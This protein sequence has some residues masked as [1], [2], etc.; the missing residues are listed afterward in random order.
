MSN[1]KITIEVDGEQLNA[2]PGQM[3]IEVT[4]AA[5]I[6][7]PR[8]CYHK[9]LSVAANCRMCLVEVEKAPKPLPACATPCMDGMK[10]Y[11]KSPTARAAQK[12]TMEFLLINHP[13]DCPIC[14]QGGECEL[15]DVAM[16][17]GGDVSRYS[18]RKRVVRDENLGPLIATDMTR[19]IHCT[20]CV[21]FGGEVAGLR[22]MGATGRGEH[23][24]IGVFIEQS[25]ASE[26]SG[27][28][29]DLCPVGALTSKPFRYHAR[30]WELTQRDSIAPHDGVGSNLHLHIR[31]DEV[32][33]AVPKENDDCNQTWI[34]DRDRFS[35]S[36]IGSED[37]IKRPMV[38]ENSVLREADWDEALQIAAK[39]LRSVPASQVGVLISPNSTLEE[40]YL[41][42]KLARGIGSENID[43]RL[44]QVD[45]RGDN[46]N[47]KRPWLG[48]R[49]SEIASND[50]TFLIGSWLRKDQPLLNHRVRQSYQSGGSVMAL[51]PIAYDFNYELDMETVCSPTEMVGH[52]A[53]I[54]DALGIDISGLPVIKKEDYVYAA[55]KLKEAKTGHFILGTAALMHPDF[56]V[57]RGLVSEISKITNLTWGTVGFGANDTGAW[58][59]DA[60]PYGNDGKNSQQMLDGSCEALLLLGVEPEADTA[61][62]MKTFKALSDANVIALTSYMTPYLEK[63]AD[64]ILP[65]GTFAETSG[66]FVNL[67]GD[68][69]S[70]HGAV[71]PLGESRP[72][73]KILRVLG[74]LTDLDGFDYIDSVEVRD[75]AV[76]E[77]SRQLHDNS[78]GSSDQIETS[79]KN[80]G[81][82]RIG[83][84]PMYATDAIV[85]RSPALQR[86]PDTWSDKARIN[87]QMAEGLSVQDGDSVRITQGDGVAKVK[88]KIDNGV[89][90]D[91]VWLPAALSTSRHL[92]CSFGEV[93]VEKG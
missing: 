67:Q 84:V 68:I 70:F 51:N 29:I 74:N 75:D 85:R 15:Q 42:S 91:C 31:R 72:G 37:R 47:P 71:S 86:T 38:R 22:E 56:A 43:F 11:T 55:E 58:M 69:Q 88:I 17:Y 81:I 59:V 24:K 3:L 20:R 2:E 76:K 18:E 77:N 57:L 13:L 53:G 7:V 90:D 89:P 8:F 28:I 33:R 65:M 27:N 87:N 34:S 26:L 92:G 25:V 93:R 40:M 49:F 23:M 62:P 19:C 30:S 14:D 48:Q 80:S 21:R 32:M 39:S 78:L 60:Y 52:L 12:G 5:G 44:R 82:S 4:D 16:G 61:D 36:G 79:W 10:V 41:S 50:I 1:E 83:G 54:A 64:V 6:T 66:T 73:W 63:T 46:A 45:F 35:Y 9:H